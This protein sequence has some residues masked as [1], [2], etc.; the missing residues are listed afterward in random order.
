MMGGG[1]PDRRRLQGEGRDGSNHFIPYS[2]RAFDPS[3]S[4]HWG[5]FDE[6]DSLVQIDD[7]RVGDTTVPG[8]ITAFIIGAVDDSGADLSPAPGRYVDIVT[9]KIQ[10]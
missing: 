1:G 10:F 6:P 4:P 8:V 7:L 3:G 9:A 5:D 2:I